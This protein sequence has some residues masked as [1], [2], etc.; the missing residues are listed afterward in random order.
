[1]LPLVFAALERNAASHWNPA[2]HGLTCNVRKMFQDMDEQLYEECRLR[3]EAE[4]VRGRARAPGSAGQRLPRRRDLSE[5]CL[6]SRSGVP[7]KGVRNRL[8]A[9]VWAVS[10][11][12]RPARA[13]RGRAARRAPAP[14]RTAH[15]GAAAQAQK[16]GALEDRQR[17][18]QA[19]ES[20]AQRSGTCAAAA[21][22]AG[23]G[24][25]SARRW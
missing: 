7:A 5:P 19:I 2:V 11:Q 15:A 23:A 12:A 3:Y 24:V 18:W 21:A 8:C 20:A 10:S 4:E 25:G 14:A 16:S 6:R 1:M 17:Q 9:R 22:T 13:S